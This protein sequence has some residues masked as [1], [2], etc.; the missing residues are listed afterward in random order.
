MGRVEI[1]SPLLFLL[2]YLGHTQFLLFDG[3]KFKSNVKKVLKLSRSHF[4]FLH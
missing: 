2:L 4:P 1:G 3:F